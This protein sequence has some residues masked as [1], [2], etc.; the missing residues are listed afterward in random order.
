[1]GQDTTHSEIDALSESCEQIN[2]TIRPLLEACND[3]A[4]R[5][6][7]MNDRLA[8][9]RTRLEGAQATDLVV[10]GHDCATMGHITR[11]PSMVCV[12]CGADA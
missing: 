8:E 7:R 12:V 3:L 4:S 1:M 6:G 2:S 11:E 9:I 5:V 10:P